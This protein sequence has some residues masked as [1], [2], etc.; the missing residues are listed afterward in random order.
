M[1]QHPCAHSRQHLIPNNLS[2]QH[3]G[4][5]KWI[6]Q[7]QCPHGSSSIQSA[8]YGMSKRKQL[9]AT[10][11]N[12]SAPTVVLYCNLIEQ[13]SNGTKRKAQQQ[14]SHVPYD[15][16]CFNNSSLSSSPMYRK[17]LSQAALLYKQFVLQSCHISRY[18]CKQC[19]LAAIPITAAFRRQ[20]LIELP[21]AIYSSCGALTLDL[22]TII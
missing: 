9:C 16:C 17:Q 7:Q 10:P 11:P 8:A 20:Q 6:S 14:F 22:K 19:Y 1:K 4:A 2:D 21:S 18:T 15:C 3:A 12:S 13:G 5:T